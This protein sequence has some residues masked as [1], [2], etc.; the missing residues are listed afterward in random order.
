ML[1]GV[2]SLCNPDCPGMRRHPDALPA[3]GTVVLLPGGTGP[4]RN[5][6]PG[7]RDSCWCG[8]FEVPIIAARE[9]VSERE[10][11]RPY[12]NHHVGVS[13]IAKFASKG[14]ANMCGRSTR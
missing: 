14:S 12:W 10:I 3:P 13:S 8:G 9:L 6:N 7:H 2:P 4:R 11:R 5:P 1:F